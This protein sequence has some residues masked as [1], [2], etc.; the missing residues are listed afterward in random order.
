MSEWDRR[1]NWLISNIN[2]YAGGCCL[3]VKKNMLGGGGG[4]VSARKTNMLDGCWKRKIW[5]GGGWL[6]AGRKIYAGEGK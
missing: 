1:V 3:L 2:K 6:S 4:F 5:C